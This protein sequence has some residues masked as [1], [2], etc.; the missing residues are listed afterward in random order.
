MTR[1]RH[2]QNYCIICVSISLYPRAFHSNCFWTTEF[3]FISVISGKCK[4]RR[5]CEISDSSRKW[6]TFAK[7][8]F[9]KA[10]ISDFLA[11]N[12]GHRTRGVMDENECETYLVC[13]FK[14]N[15][16]F[17]FY[18]VHQKILLARILKVK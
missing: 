11:R 18:F 15:L 3:A 12:E 4:I 2:I 16:V 6:Y 9:T 10:A 13:N 1:L 7:I 17:Y 14:N 5:H 8:I